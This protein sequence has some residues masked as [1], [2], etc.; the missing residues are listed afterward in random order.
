MDAAIAGLVVGALVGLWFRWRGSGEV[1]N[2]RNISSYGLIW[3]LV[4]AG[5]MAI[6]A[7]FN[8]AFGNGLV[9]VVALAVGLSSLIVGIFRNRPNHRK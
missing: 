3:Y 4:F 6:L 1:F 8:L 7:A 5:M 2:A 9:A